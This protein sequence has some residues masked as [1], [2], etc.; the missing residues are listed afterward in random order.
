[1]TDIYISVH[2]LTSCKTC[3]RHHK[4]AGN[5]SHESLAQLHCVHCGHPL[6]L[7]QSNDESSPE[8]H[9]RGAA[10]YREH[11]DRRETKKYTRSSRLFA[12]LIS[13][14]L[15]GGCGGAPKTDSESQDKTTKDQK[16]SGVDESAGTSASSVV[17]TSRDDIPASIYGG[18]P[19]W[20]PPPSETSPQE[21]APSSKSP[22]TEED[23]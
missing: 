18:P 14:S 22:E 12:G 16:S 2:Q 6:L 20:E 7:N 8:H 21:S 10:P 17:Q 5:T 1:M 9:S 13:L 19:T 3:H 4:V 11:R 23:E 15:M